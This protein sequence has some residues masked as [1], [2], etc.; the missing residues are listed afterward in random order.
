LEAAYFRPHTPNTQIAVVPNGVDTGYFQNTNRTSKKENLLFTG[1]MDYPPNIDGVTWFCEEI[2][3]ALKTSYPDL[4]FQ[5]VGRDPTPEVL[6]L[7][8]YSG[9]EVVGTVP[10]VRPYFDEAW[11]YVVPLRQGGGTRLKILEAMAMEVPVISTSLGCEG[12]GLT[13]KENIL[14]A[15][16]PEEYN[17]S[18]ELIHRDLDLYKSIAASG[19]AKVINEY[20]WKNITSVQE[21]FYQAVI[22]VSNQHR[23]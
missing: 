22:N 14:I 18:K 2:F 20:D 10:D 7:D 8:R 4:V 6:S 13:H 15:D 1:R 9:V 5:I 21:N 11:V 19:R 16:Q 3:P 12:L 23:P 17:Q